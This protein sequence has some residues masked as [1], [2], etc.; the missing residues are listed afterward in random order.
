LLSS[1]KLAVLVPVY[2][3]GEMLRQT[4]ESCAHA[5]LGPDQYEIIVVDNCSTDGAVHRIPFRDSQ[6]A[7]V[8]VHRNRSNLGRVGNWN[9]AV[10]I[11]Q[12][13][14]FGYVTFLFVGDSWIPVGSLPQLLELVQKMG[15]GMGFS[16]FVIA[17]AAGQV[18]RQ[19]QRFYVSGRDAVTT[20]RR[21]IQKLIESGL[22]PLGPLQ[23]NIYR[24]EPGC[25]IRFDPSLPTRTDVE[26][27]LQFLQ[28]TERPVAIV[29][30]PFFQWREYGGRF[31]MSMGAAQTIRDYIT[32]FQNAC[33]DTTVEADFGL[34]KSRLMLN[35]LRLACSEAG[36][37]EWPA[38]A[39]NLTRFAVQRPH[40]VSAAHLAKALWLRFG[41]NHRLLEFSNE[42]NPAVRYGD[43]C[44]IQ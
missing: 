36:L 11:A 1:S 15:A 7:I 28:K 12:Q 20:A 26:A 30:E 17:D 5:G 18:R 31:H 2:N 44:V 6:G 19:S 14:G 8:Q 3:G 33:E 42:R 22:F 29:A 23:A 27:T 24:V 21:F 41:R 43:Q 40:P 37:K 38:I 39:S 25:A 10:A 32:T 35:A 4:I 9:Q 16:P 34:S 13:Q